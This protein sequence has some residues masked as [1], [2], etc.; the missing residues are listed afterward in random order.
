MISIS[1]RRTMAQRAANHFYETT[2]RKGYVVVAVCKTAGR[3]VEACVVQAD[4]EAHAKHMSGVLGKE[5]TSVPRDR[6]EWLS[7]FTYKL[8]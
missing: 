8:V 5:W 3:D 6:K 4:S 1:K 2:R 7:T